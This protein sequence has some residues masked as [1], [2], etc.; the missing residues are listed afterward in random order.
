MGEGARRKEGAV[1]KESHAV[2]ECEEKPKHVT[3]QLTTKSNIFTMW[4]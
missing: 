3:A 1:Q 4:G 2:L